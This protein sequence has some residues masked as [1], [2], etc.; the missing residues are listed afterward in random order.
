MHKKERVESLTSFNTRVRRV[1][2]VGLEEIPDGD[3][4]SHDETYMVMVSAYAEIWVENAECDEEGTWYFTSVHVRNR[5]EEA[6]EGIQMSCGAPVR[7]RWKIQPWF[8]KRYNCL[9]TV[10]SPH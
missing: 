10:V 2:G 6:P 3:S 4:W 7:V 8:C 9:R 5:S 1:F